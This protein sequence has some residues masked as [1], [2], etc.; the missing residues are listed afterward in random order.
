[1]E[2]PMSRPERWE[3]DAVTAQ[4]DAARSEGVWEFD[5]GGRRAAGFT[6]FA[7]DCVT[8]AIAIGTGL[9]YRRVYD[10]LS[11]G[12]A[13]RGKPRSARNGVHPDVYKTLL[14]EIDWLWTP[15]M[16]IGS[17]CTVHLRADELPPG[18]I[19]VRLSKHLA[20]VVDGVLHDTHDS[21]RGGTR[22]VYGYWKGPDR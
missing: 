6:G 15:T 14:W 9:P 18:R 10:A 20:A 12:Q 4:V 21:S 3:V 1:M 16:R 2:H 8:R 13:A 7:G 19:I 22:C 17:G 11:A 5:D